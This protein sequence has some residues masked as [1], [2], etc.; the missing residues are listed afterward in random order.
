MALTGNLDNLR[1]LGYLAAFVIHPHL[2]YTLGSRR[3]HALSSDL[4]TVTLMFGVR[5]PCV[6]GMRAPSDQATGSERQE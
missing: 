2:G 3:Q 5:I 6:S 1:V 4:P